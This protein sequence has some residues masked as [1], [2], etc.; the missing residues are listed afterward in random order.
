MGGNAI[1]QLREPWRRGRFRNANNEF[2]LGQWEIQNRILEV[3]AK[4]QIWLLPAFPGN[5]KRR[6]K[7]SRQH[8]QILQRS[9]IG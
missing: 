7:K 8:C 6:S 4:I 2:D 3:R 5:L 9:L 1:N